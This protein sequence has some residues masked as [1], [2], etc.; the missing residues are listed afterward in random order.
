MR[1]TNKRLF[2]LYN[3]FQTQFLSGITIQPDIVKDVKEEQSKDVTNS[4]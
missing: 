2:N 4:F 1:Y 3:F